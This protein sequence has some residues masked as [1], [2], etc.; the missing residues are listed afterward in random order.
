MFK[1]LILLF[2]LL[3]LFSYEKIHDKEYLSYKIYDK[4]EDVL[5][6]LKSEIAADG[7]ILSYQANIGKGTKEISKFYN[8]KP[9][10]LNAHNI[11]FCKKSFTFKIMSENPKNIIY[12]PLSFAIYEIKENEIHILYK[13]AKELKKDE[14]VFLEIN[15]KIEN[16]IDLALEN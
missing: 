8:K 15:Q 10:Y 16:L 7:F 11:G 3:D 12:C 1:V 9:L 13:K 4:Y 2:L 6:S 14:I 5:F